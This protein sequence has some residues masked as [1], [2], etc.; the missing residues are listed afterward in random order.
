MSPPGKRSAG[1]ELTPAGAVNTNN[2]GTAA[3]TAKP[4]DDHEDSGSGMAYKAVIARA[5]LLRRSGRARYDDWL[6]R[7]C[8][9]CGHPHRHRAFETSEP[10][11]RAA[12]CQAITY[13]HHRGRRRAAG[14]GGGGRGMTRYTYEQDLEHLRGEWRAHRS[15]RAR[16]ELRAERLIRERDVAPLIAVHETGHAVVAHALG[17][18]VLCV[19][20]V[21]S[22]VCG[23]TE[24][25]VRTAD[26]DAPRDLALITAGG[27]ALGYLAG[28]DEPER[29]C[30]R[31]RW[32]VDSLG[33]GW[34]E[35]VAAARD[36]LEEGWEPTAKLVVCAL[37]TR[38][39]S[40]P[41]RSPAR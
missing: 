22:A 30:E 32:I 14:R 9:F 19:S 10:V 21:G 37:R 1:E 28:L 31:D 36:L 40:T 6:V 8:P 15:R 2:P 11:E 35:A 4:H 26:V 20:R 17:Y 24:G 39:G 38:P 13:L 23:G 12:L 7:C 5:L 29:G 3:P 34:S 16:I 25:H 27:A 33:Y 18:A 41:T